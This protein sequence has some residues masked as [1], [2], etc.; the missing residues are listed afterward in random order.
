MWLFILHL[1]KYTYMHKDKTSWISKYLLLFF[2]C[3]CLV[4]FMYAC[5]FTCVGACE[6]CMYTYV[7]VDMK[8]Q[9]WCK[10]PSL[11]TSHLTCWGRFFS[12]TWSSLLQ[13]D[14]LISLLKN[15]PVFFPING[16]CRWVTT[17]TW[18]LCEF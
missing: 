7:Y 15:L 12:W 16:D 3:M 17:C 6:S 9:G 8:G 1:Y 5:M 11:N 10:M 18:L 2:M 4:C 13:P 14:W